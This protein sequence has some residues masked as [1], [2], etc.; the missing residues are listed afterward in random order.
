MPNVHSVG[1]IPKQNEGNNPNAEYNFM[2]RKGR[3]FPFINMN[4]V[5]LDELVWDELFQLSKSGLHDWI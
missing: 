4:D 2:L 3:G 1:W 5:I